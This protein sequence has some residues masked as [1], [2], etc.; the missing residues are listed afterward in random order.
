VSEALFIAL[1]GRLQPSA[2]DA[3]A[4]A[5]FGRAAVLVPL[6]DGPDGVHL[7]FT[8]RAA[9]LR[10]HAGQISFPG[11]RLEAGEGV[12]A[13]ALRETFEEI[14]VR[15]LEGEVLGFLEDRISPTGLVATPVVARL[16]WP[17][18]TVP[19]PAEVAEVFTLPLVELL[20]KEPAVR[21]VRSEGGSRE[22][23]EYSVASRVVWGL[24]G[25]VVHDLLARIR[26]DSPA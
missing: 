24:T 7:L 10:R 17:R 20:A 1:R 21:T 3:C 5:G 8:V 23:L 16:A 25:M 14:G 26:L 11:G 6:L 12:V 18:A 13:A 4:P 2:S 15:V 19:D 9:G 22:L